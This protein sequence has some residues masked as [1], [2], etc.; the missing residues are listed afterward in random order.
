MASKAIIRGLATKFIYSRNTNRSR[1]HQQVGGSIMQAKP[2]KAGA[3]V[4][5]VI[6]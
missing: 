6:D 2:D 5:G 1:K 3:T 4:T